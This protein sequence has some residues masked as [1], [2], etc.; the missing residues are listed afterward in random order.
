MRA[1]VNKFSGSTDIKVKTATS[2]SGVKGTD[3]IVMNEG[4]AN[5]V[6]AE[7]SRV[8]VRGDG[9]RPVYVAS[10]AMTENTK[11]SSPIRPV[12]VERG[13]LLDEARAQLE[14]VT[15][16]ERPVEWEKTGRLPEILARWNI[17][18]GHYLADSK[19]FKDSLDVFMIA[20]DLSGS[21]E[22]K[23]EA[24]I[25]RGTVLS[26]NLNEPRAAL[27]EYMTVVERLSESS[28][29]E[30]AVFSAGMIN[31]E[32][33]EKDKALFLFKRYLN[34]YPQGGH[35]GTIEQFIRGMGKD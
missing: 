32:I 9:G 17:N 33:G 21:A 1:I 13:S 2:V 28:F 14:A 3:F 6:F 22:L 30:N 8:M 20:I 23:A 4:Q 31:M 29:T 19:R 25:E 24:R 16:I 15:D 26:R 11:G 27:E 10:G 12:K 7:E 35:R 18:Y 5:V 34:E